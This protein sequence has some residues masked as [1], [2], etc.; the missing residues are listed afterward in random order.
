ME[1]GSSAFPGSLSAQSRAAQRCLEVVVHRETEIRHGYSSLSLREGEARP[2]TPDGELLETGRGEI[3]RDRS[4]G[5]VRHLALP[6][7]IIS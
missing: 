5:S 6:E 2:M 1:Q 3:G 4:C 7:N